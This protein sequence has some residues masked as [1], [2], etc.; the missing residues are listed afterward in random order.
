MI[1]LYV[2][3][4]AEIAIFVYLTDSVGVLEKGQ[5]LVV[6]YQF[7]TSTTVLDWAE[8]FSIVPSEMY[9]DVSSASGALADLVFFCNPTLMT[10]ESYTT[11][12]KVAVEK[13][14]IRKIQRYRDVMYLN[15]YAFYI[16]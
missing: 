10:L 15:F 13:G 3:Q 5:S 11:E 2:S 12:I 6:V 7:I 9:M 16:M 14:C 1:Q 4:E 8:R